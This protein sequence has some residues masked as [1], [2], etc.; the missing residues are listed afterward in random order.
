MTSAETLVLVAATLL[1]LAV[2][3]EEGRGTITAPVGAFSLTLALLAVL[4]V[5]VHVVAR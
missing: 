4:V 3:V 5:L 2:F 1:V